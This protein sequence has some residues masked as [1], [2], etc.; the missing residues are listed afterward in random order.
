[1]GIQERLGDG[2][3]TGKGRPCQAREVYRLLVRD[4]GHTGSYKAV[5]RHLAR[6]Y[7][8]PRVRALRRVET[9]PGVQAEHD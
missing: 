4:Y 5:V 7:G 3:L 6:R 9:Q 2:R 8:R 1:L